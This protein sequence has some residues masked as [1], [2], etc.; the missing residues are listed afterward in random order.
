MTPTRVRLRRHGR[1]SIRV[2]RRQVELIE[3]FQRGFDA[4]LVEQG[5]TGDLGGSTAA[6]KE[7]LVHHAVDCP[8]VH[9]AASRSA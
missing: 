3:A 7:S 2:T 5:M 6:V 8:R 1:P 9:Q 4:R